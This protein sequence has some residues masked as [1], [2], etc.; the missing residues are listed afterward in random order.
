MASDPVTGVASGLTTSA[1][2]TAKGWADSSLANANSALAAL[3]AVEYPYVN[4]SVGVG[5]SMGGGDPVDPAIPDLPPAPGNFLIPTKPTLAETRVVVP[6]TKPDVNIPLVP[7]L[8]PITM[9]VKPPFSTPALDNV[10]LGTML[11]ILIPN[12]PDVV[13]PDLSVTPPNP[14]SITPGTYSFSVDNILI[15]DDPLVKAMIAR[16]KDNVQNGGTGLTPAIEAAIFARDLERSEQQLSDA[17]D[18]ATSMWAKKGFPLPD[19]LLAD[20][21]AAIQIE[22]MNRNIDRSREIMIKQADLEQSNL[23]KSIELGVNLSFKLIDA[24]NEYQK[25]VISAQEMTAKY[26]NE[27]I[28]LQLATHNSN[29]ELFKARVQMHEITV[30][31]AMTEVEIYKA[32]LEGELAKVNINEQTVKIYSTQIEAA[33]VKYRGIIEGNKMLTDIFTAEIQGALAESQLQESFIK[34]YAEKIRAAMAV[35]EVY[36]AEVD[37]MVAEISGEKMKIEGNVALID[38]WSKE[39]FA[40][41]KQV[42]IDLEVYK[43][44]GTL[45]ISLAELAN[46]I[47]ETEI[48]L[49]IERS[50]LSLQNMQLQV[51]QMMAMGNAKV[52]SA[53][54]VAASAA[55][56]AAGA[57][58]AVNAS[59]GVSFSES[60]SESYS[61][62]LAL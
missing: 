14:I 28:T 5:M 34:V 10:T 43:T 62:S 8:L 52:E 49:S 21:L 47:N 15:S 19:G 30:R 51:T 54:A 12:T 60:A 3:A 25:L 59:T 11:S 7:V 33:L 13:I 61:E 16:L 1:M 9:P 18:K 36:K 6:P 41:A 50:K 42:E 46:K 35:I 39:V 48:N 55:S 38:M 29:I 44:S 57:M 24:L 17:I 56:M 53:K 26:A 37:A 32:Q 23:F 58:A 4:L 31:A 40:N 45:T 2:A 27:Y 22:Y 20:S